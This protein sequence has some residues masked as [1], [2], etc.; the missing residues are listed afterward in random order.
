MKIIIITGMSGAGKS[1]AVKVFEDLGY[2]VVDNLPP[3]L[4]GKFVD[5]LTSAKGKINE[6]AMVMDIRSGHF[7]EGIE[8]AIEDL[9]ARHLDYEILFL[10]AEDDELVTRFKETRRVH[11]LSSRERLLTGIQKEREILKP[12]KAKADYVIDTTGLALRNFQDKIKQRYVMQNASHDFNITLVSF[13]FKYGVPVDADLIFDVRFIE[14]PFYIDELRPQ[15]GL[16]EPVQNFVLGNEVT[17]EFIKKTLDLLLFLIPHYVEEGKKQ[18]IIGIG[19][20]G[21]RHRSVAITDE[22]TKELRFKGHH[23]TSFHRDL[24]EDPA[25]RHHK[26]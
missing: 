18:L 17:R 15:S 5:V 14:N 13:G 8:E 22:L 11:P 7:F 12:I 4:L 19:C 9:N 25:R 2:F 16:D 1:Q 3:N 26:A 24:E 6:V 21:G 23:N 20:T 10:D